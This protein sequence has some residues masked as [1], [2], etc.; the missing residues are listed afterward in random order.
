[1]KL[2]YIAE[3]PHGAALPLPE[4]WPAADHDE[5]DR[6]AADAKVASGAYR[7]EHPPRRRAQEESNGDRD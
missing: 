3:T 1:V 2:R 5:P 4:G 6:E 7:Y